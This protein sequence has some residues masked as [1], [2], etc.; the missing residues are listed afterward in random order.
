M[1]KR[2]HVLL[3]VPVVKNIAGEL[4]ISPLYIVAYVGVF[5]IF[6]KRFNYRYTSLFLLSFLL[7]F[8]VQVDS[9]LCPQL[10]VHSKLY[11]S[12]DKYMPCHIISDRCPKSCKNRFRG[13]HCAKSQ[14][15]SR[16]CPCFAADRECD[17][18]VCR[19]CW[20]R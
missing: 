7:F 18:D 20:I 4:T 13:C 3:M 16:Q 1:E 17:P 19:N 15:R 11:G 2:A 6:I 9:V 12:T 14:C 8:Y 5:F 10:V